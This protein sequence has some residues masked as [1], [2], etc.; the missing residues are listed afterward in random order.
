M[1]PFIAFFLVILTS[2]FS[3]TLL[4]KL[5]LPW[6]AA[7]IVGGI[8][9]GKSGLDIIPLND[10][11]DFIAQMGLIFL[12]FMAGFET[13]LS[14]F[15]NS[16]KNHMYYLAFVNGFIPF[17]TG[18]LI[19]QYLGY[20]PLASLLMGTVFVS[21]S[22]AVVIPTLEA[23]DMIEHRLGKS[24]ISAII[25]QDV[26]S[27]ILLSILLQDT[28]PATELPLFFFYPL[29]LLTLVGLRNILPKVQ[30]YFNKNYEGDDLFQQQLRVVFLILLG[31]VIF[32]EMLGL[33]SIIGGFFA[34]LVLS[35]SVDH[36]VILGKLRAISYGF[37]IP[38]FFIVV[39]MK[40]DLSVL[41]NAENVLPLIILIVLGSV[42]SKFVS[43]FLG[44]RIVSFNFRDAAFFGASSIPQLS[45]TLAV[46]YTA[47]EFGIIDENL[48]TALV[49]LS[50]IT[51]FFG[52][53]LMRAIRKDLE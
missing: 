35:E 40:T 6:V 20:S 46:A 31:T 44:A 9:M 45:T 16:R 36:D 27:L 29:L 12:M 34:G 23:N 42:L 7:L 32:F 19:S 41:A 43:G 26:A 51:T 28:Q 33:H 8:L 25:V 15:K 21:S 50:I 22:I 48:N 52:P 39:G 30:E 24:V 13:R 2:I 11:V 47:R 10:T 3:S 1:Q 38:T 37:F 4:K 5:H 18:I 17:L 49:L 14:S 53:T